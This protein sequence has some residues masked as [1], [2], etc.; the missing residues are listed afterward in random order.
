VDLPD[1]YETTPTYPE[2]L[3][4]SESDSSWYELHSD[5]GEW[6]YVMRKNKRG[7]EFTVYRYPNPDDH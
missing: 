5:D 4:D 7:D 2:R 6:I 3:P 1:I